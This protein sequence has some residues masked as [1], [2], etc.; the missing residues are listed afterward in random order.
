MRRRPQMCMVT[1]CRYIALAGVTLLVLAPLSS[2]A[3]RRVA[4]T[5]GPLEER[6]DLVWIAPFD[7]V[8]AP[9]VQLMP[10]GAYRRNPW[11]WLPWRPRAQ[12]LPPQ[13]KLDS[14][15]TR[16]IADSAATKRD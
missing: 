14:V 11:W 15:L 13:A 2:C 5:P 1:W 8:G 3:P 6:F 16:W 10:A 12:T 7:S 9:Q 4:P